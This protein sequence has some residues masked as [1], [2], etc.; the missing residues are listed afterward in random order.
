MLKLIAA[1]SHASP[2]PLRDVYNSTLI[3]LIPYVCRMFKEKSDTAS[4]LKEFKLYSSTN[5]GHVNGGN[6]RKVLRR[7]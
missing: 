6:K 2:Y 4:Y 5:L 3:L 1:P 7:S